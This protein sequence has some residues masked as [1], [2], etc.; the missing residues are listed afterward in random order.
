MEVG[1][2]NQAILAKI[3]KLRE[4]NVGSMIPLPQLVVVGDQS[5]GKSSVLENLT[6]FSFPR[7][8]GLCTRYATQITCCRDPLRSVSISIIPRPDAS[9]ELKAELLGFQRALGDLENDELAGIFEEANTAMDIRMGDDE[10]ESGCGAFSEDILKIE[11]YGPDQNHLTVIDVPGI[12]RVPTPGLTTETDIVLVENMVKRYMND[13]RT[14]ILAVI[15]C[16]VDIATQEIVQLAEKADPDG[17]RTMGVLTKP[18]LATEAATQKAVVDL[19]LGKR[20]NL[21]LGYYVVKNRGADDTSGDWTQAKRAAAEKAFFANQPWVT[22]RERCGVAT[23]KGRLRNLLMAI[24]KQEIPNVKNDIDQRLRRSRADLEAMGPPRSDESSQRQFLGRLASQFQTVTHA[25]LNGYYAGEKL[26]K[27]DPQLKLITRVINLHNIFSKDFGQ[28]AHMR[29]FDGALD[30]E[31]KLTKK[32][33]TIP[34]A[35]P[36][37]QYRELDDIV[38]IQDSECAMPEDKPIM[39]LIRNVYDSSRGPDLGTFGGTVLST[40]FEEQSAKWEALSLS[41]VSNPI[42]VVHNYVFRLL[43]HLCP[44]KHIRDQIWDGYLV[45]ELSELYRKAMEHA[46][47]LLK[48]ERGRPTTFNHYFNDIVQKKRAERVARSLENLSIH[49]DEGMEDG[50]CGQ[51]IPLDQIENAATNKDNEQQ[52]CEDILDTFVSYYKVARKRFVDVIYQQVI[53]HFLLNGDQSPVKAFGPEMIMRLD[54][55]QLNMIAG[56]DEESR[57]QRSTLNREIESLT[58]ALKVL[59]SRGG[60]SHGSD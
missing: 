42:A 5:S 49:L 40:V 11:I 52:L 24:S 57:H 18:D 34:F 7:A 17:V 35:I 55:E 9:E 46:R 19:V 21:K 3:D 48:I 16:N 54:D 47:F 1:L 15:P 30:E 4:L 45:E 53:S 20:S 58:A 14:I 59:R 56:E 44:E 41:H 28:R 39:D 60:A 27:D 25:A 10:D 13:S 8:A 2:G 29:Q 6:G 50:F 43:R 31:G 37:D 51:C 32:D 38:F 23:L 33:T 26:F 12:F 22:I 36:L